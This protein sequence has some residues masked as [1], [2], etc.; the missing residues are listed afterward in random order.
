MK[1]TIL[2]LMAFVMTFV[3]TAPP[4]QTL[5]QSEEELECLTCSQGIADSTGTLAQQ[6]EAK[7]L[8]KESEQH[9]LT[10]DDLESRGI[11]PNWEEHR[12][13]VEEDTEEIAAVMLPIQFGEITTGYIQYGVNYQTLEV[14][15]LIFL[16]EAVNEELLGMTVSMNGES[17]YYVEMNQEGEIFDEDG[18]NITLEQAVA[19]AQSNQFQMFSTCKKLANSFY[20]ALNTFSWNYACI[21]AA[22]IMTFWG[23]LACVTL[24]GLAREMS[25]SGFV[26]MICG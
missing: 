19:E 17:L 16:M 20:T 7:K 18:N 1:K 22:G 26:K 12:I 14:E 2:L 13:Y 11:V 9:Q 6:E 21:I 24:C 5:A 4:L 15:E 23:G 25:R 8:V 3:Y 10:I